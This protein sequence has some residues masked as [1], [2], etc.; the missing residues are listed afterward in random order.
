MKTFDELVTGLTAFLDAG[1]R[2]YFTGKVRA[3]WAAPPEAVL[4]ELRLGFEQTHW[5]LDWT[6]RDRD[7]K[8]YPGEI[9]AL[10]PDKPGE[11]AGDS[12]Q[13]AVRGL[14]DWDAL[15]EAL[16]YDIAEDE[17]DMTLFLIHA[18]TAL[19]LLRLERQ[20]LA[21]LDVTL[22]D[23]FR[24]IQFDDIEC[25]VVPMKCPTYFGHVFEATAVLAHLDRLA[26]APEIRGFLK[27]LFAH[28]EAYLEGLRAKKKV[29]AEPLLD[30]AR[31]CIA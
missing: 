26:E 4:A 29:K 20:S 6:W 28:S 2:Q 25:A 12:L 27:R 30:V 7:G 13:D 19:A 24:L 5:Y 8:T 1:L 10:A 3:R 11:I 23:D 31:A 21:K 17:T 22:A 15:E 18:A 9:T 14:F 16:D